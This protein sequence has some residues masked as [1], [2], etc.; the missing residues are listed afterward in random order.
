M[1]V[2]QDRVEEASTNTKDREEESE[3]K[4]EVKKKE[5]G[6]LMEVNVAFFV[7]LFCLIQDSKSWCIDNL[8]H[9]EY[10]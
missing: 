6:S 10:I 7:S 2:E 4:E 5:G 3:D 8:F 1:E 9:F